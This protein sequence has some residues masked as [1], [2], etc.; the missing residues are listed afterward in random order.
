MISCRCSPG[1]AKIAG[2]DASGGDAR[3]SVGCGAIRCKMIQ[4]LK[5][6]SVQFRLP[7][8]DATVERSAALLLC[9]VARKC[10]V[11]GR[12]V[13]HSVFTR[14]DVVGERRRRMML[15]GG[16]MRCKAGCRVLLPHCI[17]VY[18]ILALEFR[19]VESLFCVA[20]RCHAMHEIAERCHRAY[21]FHQAALKWNAA[22]SCARVQGLWAI[23]RHEFRRILQKGVAIH[24]SC[25]ISC[26]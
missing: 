1:V 5:L 24:R 19:V 4:V 16:A 21:S 17:H 6:G 23:Q 3:E 20:V 10:N 12:S 11:N 9:V 13:Y 7:Q 8:G 14:S 25:C 15:H 18:H 26:C 22:E 2:E